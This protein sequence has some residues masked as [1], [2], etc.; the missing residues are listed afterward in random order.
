MGGKIERKEGKERR[1]V[2]KREGEEREDERGEERM[3]KGGEGR[4]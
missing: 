1:W 4:Q 3:M 2:K